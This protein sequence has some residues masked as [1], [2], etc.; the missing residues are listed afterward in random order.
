MGPAVL[1]RFVSIT[2]GVAVL[3][4]L[5][6]GWAGASLAQSGTHVPAS[7]MVP[8]DAFYERPAEVPDEPGMLLKSEPL[9]DREIPANAQA[10]RIQYTT[11]LPDG[12]PGL[13][14]ATV[15]APAELPPGPLPV[16]AWEHGTV[17]I[18]QRC[19]LSLARTPFAGIPALDQVVAQGWVIVATDYA[20]ND[21][22]VI[23]YLIGEGEAHA[24]LDSVRAARQ[25][26][27]LD[28]A[29]QTVVWGHSQGGQAALWTGMIGERY[30]PDI[31]L[32]GVAALA[33]AT[34]MAG[35]LASH[36]GDPTGARLGAYGAV[37]F[38]QYYPDVIFGEIVS[39]E[40]QDIA[41]QMADLCQFDPVDISTLQA[42]TAELDG[43]PVV[44]DPYAGALGQRL[45]QNFP[46]GPIA[47]PLLIAQGLDDVVIAPH[48]NDEFVAERCADGQ[49]LLYWR[50][51]GRD[52]GGIVQPD[53][54]L[55][56]PLIAWT[57]D[58]YAGLESATGCTEETIT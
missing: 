44:F 18:L 17:G 6:T 56:D 25:I 32:A 36:G 19:M 58:R 5:L 7:L 43:L 27:E 30:A 48:F 16:I 2:A 20:V 10:W 40:A 55:A 28:L 39:P 34:D 52:H 15:L 24:G 47:A 31:E 23:T 42:L 51:P 54:P 53:S 26:P 9:L 41:R 45:E 22:N 3:I 13:A 14:V 29:D 21:Q 38:S 37:A 11:T 4:A 57:A 12:S 35:I 33:P 50:I 8:I 49:S 1:R 46:G